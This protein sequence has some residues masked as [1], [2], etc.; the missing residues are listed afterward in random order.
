MILTYLL[1]SD[2]YFGMVNA[3]SSKDWFY[4]AAD[5]DLAHTLLTFSL[6]GGLARVDAL[7]DPLVAFGV[8]SGISGSYS[9]IDAGVV[10]DLFGFAHE[11]G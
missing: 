8:T 11:L 9:S 6:G 3:Y 10:W 1:S 7:C 2:A 5:V 4:Q